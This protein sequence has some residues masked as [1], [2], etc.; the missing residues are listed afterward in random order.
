MGF[1]DFLFRKVAESKMKSM[2]AE[3]RDKM[4]A[5]LEKNPEFFQKI[6]LEAQEEMSKGKN[7]MDAMMHV[8]QKHQDELKGLMS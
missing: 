1:K 5:L 3:D 2:S 8:I 4:L 7:Q 6:A